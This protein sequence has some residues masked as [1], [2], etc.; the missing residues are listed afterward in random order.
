MSKHR[1]GER[2]NDNTP[3]TAKGRSQLEQ[4]KQPGTLGTMPHF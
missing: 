4:K 1:T 2:D 3:M